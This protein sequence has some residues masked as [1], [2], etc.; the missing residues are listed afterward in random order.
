MSLDN[1]AAATLATS[2]DG[3]TGPAPQPNPPAQ[4]NP[5]AQPARAAPVIVPPVEPS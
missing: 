2:A 4:P 5:A 3:K 1:K